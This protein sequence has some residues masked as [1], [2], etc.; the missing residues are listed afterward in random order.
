MANADQLIEIYNEANARPAGAERDRF[1]ADACGGDTELREQVLALLQ[2]HQNSGDF[3]KTPVFPPAAFVTEKRGDT[4]GRYT[5]LEKLGEGGCG[6]VYVAEQSAPV[7]RR[8]ALKIV[9]L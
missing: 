8:V 6:V 3:L 5:L 9:K 4:I 7:R 2:S 1:L